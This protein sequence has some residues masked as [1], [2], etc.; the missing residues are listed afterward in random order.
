MTLPQEK[1]VFAACAK[2]RPCSERSRA[3]HVAEIL[4]GIIPPALVL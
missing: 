1:P 2:E 4:S 3:F